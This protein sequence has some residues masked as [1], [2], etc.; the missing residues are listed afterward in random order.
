MMNKLFRIAITPEYISDAEPEYVRLLADEGWDMIHLR[1]PAASLN[2]MRRLIEAIPQKYHCKLKLHGHFELT[3]HFNLGGVHLNKRC[4]SPPANWIGGISCSFHSI[5][6]IEN[7]VERYDYVTL[8]PVFDS[9]SKKGYKGSI[10]LENFAEIKKSLNVKVI[11]L[12]GV[13]P[14]RIGLLRRYGFDGYA[15]LGAIFDGVENREM[16]VER[17]NKFK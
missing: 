14:E 3:N 2:E 8:S 17:L 7:C 15:A 13:D 9:I 6:E 10:D 5:N 4:P 16:F 11:A 12:G 1:H